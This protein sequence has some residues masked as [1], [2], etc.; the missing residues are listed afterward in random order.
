MKVKMSFLVPCAAAILAT[1]LFG[2]AG[3]HRSTSTPTGESTSEPGAPG[4]TGSTG[5]PAEARDAVAT[6]EGKSGSKMTGLAAF[7]S[8]GKKVVLKIDLA[9]APPGTHAVHIHEKGDCSSADGESAGPHW[10]PTSQQHGKFGHDGFHLGDIGNIDVNQDGTG[11]LTMDTDLWTIGTGERNDV[12]GHAVVV[13]AMQDDMASQPAGNSGIRV[14]C[15]VIRR[16]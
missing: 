4:E 10:N 12:V 8:D 9:G 11:T 1:S 2:C 7:H 3:Q 13:H 15:G 5:A 14:A 6:L 16:K